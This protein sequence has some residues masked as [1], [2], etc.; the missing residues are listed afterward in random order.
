MKL[1]LEEDIMPVGPILNPTLEERAKNTESLL[2]F[3]QDSYQIMIKLSEK[4]KAPKRGIKTA[5]KVK[6]KYAERL[7]E[8]ERTDFLRLS[9]SELYNITEELSN[10]VSAIRKARDLL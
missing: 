7:K 5:E 3:V 8:W 10:A 4:E 2:S 6:K 1:Y 9:A